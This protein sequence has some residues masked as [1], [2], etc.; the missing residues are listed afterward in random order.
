MASFRPESQKM[1]GRWERG[2]GVEGS[3]R[4]PLWAAQ[5]LVGYNLGRSSLSA[6]K[7]KWLSK[8][9]GMHVHVCAHVGVGW[10]KRLWQ[11]ISVEPSG[12]G[13]SSKRQCQ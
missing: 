13:W 6:W 11:V 2:V 9:Q 7:G 8:E 3:K 10:P 1:E 12:I 5:M 4:I